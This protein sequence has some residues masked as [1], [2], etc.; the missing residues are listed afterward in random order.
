MKKRKVHFILTGGTIDSFYNPATESSVP[1][2]ASVIPYYIKNMIKP[3][4]APSFIS[5]SKKDSRYMTEATRLKI[6]DA[7]QKTSAKQIVIVHGTT[8]MALT[9]EFISKN[10]SKIKGKTVILT[11]AMVP[12]KEFVQSDGGFNLGYAVASLEHLKPGVYVCMNARTFK[13]G[14]TGKNEKEARFEDL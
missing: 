7:I 13:A 5:V 2:K 3:H 1:N 9:A 6:V 4:F 14:E 8:T 10:K 11:G 12:L